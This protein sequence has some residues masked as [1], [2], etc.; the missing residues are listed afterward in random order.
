[1][2]F[3]NI[4]TVFF[5]SGLTLNTDDLKAAFTRRTVAGTLFV[6]I[7][8]IGITPNLGWAMRVGNAVSPEVQNMHTRASLLFP[9]SKSFFPQENV[10]VASSTAVDML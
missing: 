8:I 7:S 1:M 9:P 3:I 5:I 4:C 6:L 2:T 10:A